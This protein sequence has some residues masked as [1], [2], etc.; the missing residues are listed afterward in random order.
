MK[1][2]PFEDEITYLL[3]HPPTLPKFT[4]RNEHR[5]LSPSYVWVSTEDQLE[6][7]AEILKKEQAFAVDTEQHSFRS[8]LGFTALMQVSP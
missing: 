8:F 7:L 6:S 5:D 1:E 3:D 4:I 2:H